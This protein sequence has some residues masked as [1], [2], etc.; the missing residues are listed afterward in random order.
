[1][2]RPCVKAGPKLS[3]QRVLAGVAQ[4]ARRLWPFV[5]KKD[6]AD[7]E[8]DYDFA[9]EMVAAT[10]VDETISRLIDIFA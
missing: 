5:L 1:M 2:S 4:A 10:P 6:C 8:Y 7:P 9:R 3:P